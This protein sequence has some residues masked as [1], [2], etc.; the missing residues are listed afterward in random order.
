MIPN[1]PLVELLLPVLGIL[2]SAGLE[3]LVRKKDVASRGHNIGYVGLEDEACH[4]AILES[5]YH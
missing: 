2:G 3:I 4:L 5:L 1:N